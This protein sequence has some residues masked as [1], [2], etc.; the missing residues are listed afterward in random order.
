MP[1]VEEICFKGPLESASRQPSGLRCVKLLLS[2]PDNV[3]RFCPGRH[4]AYTEKRPSFKQ[5]VSS[6]RH[7]DAASRKDYGSYPDVRRKKAQ[8]CY[9]KCVLRC[10]CDSCSEDE[11][12]AVEIEC[13]P[14]AFGE[15]GDMV[16]ICPGPGTQLC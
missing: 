16:S 3:Y 7:A 5:L 12:E 8:D 4:Q 9:T 14:Y 2:Y 11:N 15:A 6:W 13:E 10:T 1:D